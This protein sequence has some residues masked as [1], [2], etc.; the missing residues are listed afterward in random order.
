MEKKLQT[1]PNIFYFASFASRPAALCQL[2]RGWPRTINLV[3]TERQWN[4]YEIRRGNK[5][6][7]TRR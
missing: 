6:D 1:L 3:I 2:A 7:V 4:L 5:V